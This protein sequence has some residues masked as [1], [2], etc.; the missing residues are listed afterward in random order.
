METAELQKKHR[1]YPW[2][3][4][5]VWVGG[6]PRVAEDRIGKHRERKRRR[7]GLREEINSLGFGLYLRGEVDTLGIVFHFCVLLNSKIALN[8]P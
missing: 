6:A 2:A 4:V 1:V 3:A 5:D 8:I 7:E